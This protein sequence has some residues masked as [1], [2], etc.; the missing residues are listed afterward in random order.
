[1]KLLSPG[2]LIKGKPLFGAACECHGHRRVDRHQLITIP[3]FGTQLGSRASSVLDPT[4]VV[5]KS[6]QSLGADLVMESYL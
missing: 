6:V 3:I 2:S 1:M 5:Q 4:V